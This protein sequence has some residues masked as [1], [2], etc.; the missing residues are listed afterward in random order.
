MRKG[1]SRIICAYP[2]NLD[3]VYDIKCEEVAPLALGARA[4]AVGMINSLEDLF[5]ALLFCMREGS[6]AELLIEREE[7]KKRIE[8]QFQWSLRLG[9]NAG[10]MA[11]VLATLGAKPVLNAPALSRRMARMLHPGVAV[12]VGKGLISPIRAAGEMEMMHFVF[13]FK[14]GESLPSLQGKITAKNDNR[15]IA[16]FD[17]LNSRLHSNKDFDDYCLENILDLDGAL[18]SGFHLAPLS[19]Y[20]E[21]Y[22]QKLLQIG[23]WKR[24]N[25]RI[26]IHAEMGSFQD[27]R[28][29]KYLLPRLCADS[30]GLNEDELAMIE[31]VGPGWRGTVEAALRLRADLGVRRIGVHTRDFILSAMKGLI[32]PEAEIEALTRG[33]NAAA[34][35]ASTG[36]A[37]SPPP[38]EVNAAGLLA[39]DEFC[40]DGAAATGRGAFRESGGVIVCLVPSLLARRPKFTVGLGDTSTA[41]TFYEELMAINSHSAPK[42]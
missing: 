9:G 1:S 19:S 18:I 10:I 24:K 42:R 35:M 40:Q 29:M 14:K 26:Y 38:K 12:P 3:A 37:M 31:G 17:P 23:S 21:I 16:S 28:M 2:I 36:S 41:V 15:L 22:E 39:R 32:E 4:E 13:Q 25:P 30:I 20:K 34:S 8:A 33:A 5:S 7:V 6:G 11:N 27:P